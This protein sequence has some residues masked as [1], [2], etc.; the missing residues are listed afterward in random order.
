MSNNC[1]AG[2]TKRVTLCFYSSQVVVG[3]SVRSKRR[4]LMFGR[5]AFITQ[6]RRKC[7]CLHAAFNGAMQCQNY[8]NPE[9]LDKV[10][11]IFSLKRDTVLMSFY[12]TLLMFDAFLHSDTLNKKGSFQIKVT[13]PK[14]TFYQ[15]RSYQIWAP[16]CSLETKLNMPFCG[17]AALKRQSACHCFNYSSLNPSHLPELQSYFYIFMLIQHHTPFTKYWNW[18]QQSIDRPTEA[19]SKRL[20]VSWNQASN[21][22]LSIGGYLPVLRS[23]H[24]LHH[25]VSIVKFSPPMMASLPVHIGIGSKVNNFSIWS[26]FASATIQLKMANT[27]LLVFPKQHSPHS[28]FL[29]EKQGG[30]FFLLSQ[31]KNM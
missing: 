27:S 15:F 28:L 20:F 9:F 10:D 19:F 2:F 24:E 11:M 26:T 12:P 7:L 23:R 17:P 18:P 6:M 16:E 21:T 25:L 13:H 14:D 30:S 29:R 22:C 31:K 4:I 1:G 5:T 3:L 8:C